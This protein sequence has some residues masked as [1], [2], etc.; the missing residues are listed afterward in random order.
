MYDMIWI[1]SN[2]FTVAAEHKVLKTKLKL[3]SYYVYKEILLLDIVT[4]H[5][6]DRQETL[7]KYFCL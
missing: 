5:E 7:T 2:C 6:K 4:T 3:V 1:A